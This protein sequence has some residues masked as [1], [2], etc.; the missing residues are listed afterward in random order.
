MKM[1]WSK[2]LV[3]ILKVIITILSAGGGAFAAHAL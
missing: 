2:I 3:E 1:N